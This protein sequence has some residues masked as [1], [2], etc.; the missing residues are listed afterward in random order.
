MRPVSFCGK[1][2]GKKTG[3]TRM[4]PL[5]GR[6]LLRLAKKKGKT[7]TGRDNICLRVGKKGKK[8]ELKWV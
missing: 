8:E 1:T 7:E 4:Y 5:Y 3:I 6:G 2:S